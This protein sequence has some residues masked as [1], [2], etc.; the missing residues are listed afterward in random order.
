[1]RL[2]Y[3][4][5][6]AYI[7]IYSRH[8]LLQSTGSHHILQENESSLSGNT[9][10][11]NRHSEERAHNQVHSETYLHLAK[12]YR[13]C[14]RLYQLLD[15]TNKSRA[16]FLQLAANARYYRSMVEKEVERLDRTGVN[17][18]LGQKDRGLILQ[19]LCDLEKQVPGW[20]YQNLCWNTIYLRT[21]W[22][23]ATS[24]LYIAL[25]SDLKSWD[26]SDPVTHLFRI[27]FLCDNL[28]PKGAPKYAHQHVH[29]S[30]HPGYSINR[31]QEFFQIFGDHILRIL[32]MVKHGYSGDGYEIPPLDT[33]KILWNCDPDVVGSHLT[34]ETFESLVDKAIT[35]LQEL[36]PPKTPLRSLTHDQALMIMT[37]LD[38]PQGDTGES[39]LIR[40]ITFK[41]FALWMCQSHV[42][43]R[44]NYSALERLK[45]FVVGHGGHVDMHHSA[46]RVELGS[47]AEAV[48]FCTL[49]TAAKH[50]FEISIKLNWRAIRSHVKELC[51][52][53]AKNRRNDSGT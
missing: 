25:P 9:P 41:Q 45:A 14:K 6:A 24:S 53:I 49:L 52:D 10:A 34:K 5:N 30:N 42:H 38:V 51:L 22:Y 17:V 48:Q 15:T 18:K 2:E 50:V 21:K 1:M 47:S 37:F 13:F 11:D 44:F 29:I 26:N 8:R 27:Y 31:P 16:R 40:Y 28:K 7:V 3:Q 32:R 33:F 35:H 39:N 4:P 19:K 36:S 23:F 12:M 43:Q 20:D 46:L